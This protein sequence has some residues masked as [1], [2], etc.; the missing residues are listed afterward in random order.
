MTENLDVKTFNLADA[1][2]GGRTY[3]ETTVDVYFNEALGFAIKTLRDG[4]ALAERTGE[5]D[6]AERLQGELDELV[7]STP[8]HTYKILLRGIPSHVRDN[9]TDQV[10]S[11]HPTKMDLFGRAEPN[12]AADNMYNRLTWVSMVQTI[13]APDGAVVIASEA[14]V[15]MLLKHL[16]ET[17]QA[18][19]AK[20]ILDLTKGSKA[21]FEFAA[22]ELDFL[23][24]P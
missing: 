22:Q 4:V 16:P 9:I 2:A 3:P 10:S 23:S 17:S 19:V 6:E 7:K 13:T 5:E 1:I 20:A 21:G 15:D 8:Q 24:K 14:D 12:P 18:D 11:E